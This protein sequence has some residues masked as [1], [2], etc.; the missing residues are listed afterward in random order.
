MCIM[1]WLLQIALVEGWTLVSH[2][3][4]KKPANLFYNMYI[5]SGLILCL[6]RHNEHELIHTTFLQLVQSNRFDLGYPP[7]H[8]LKKHMLS[9]S[10]SV[11][12]CAS[13]FQWSRLFV[14]NIQYLGV[15]IPYRIFSWRSMFMEAELL[16]VYHVQGPVVQKPVSL[17]LG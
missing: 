3:N 1:F 2:W 13:E 17:T 14:S 16:V 9:Y 5:P 7:I 4:H 6:L 10:L 12:W 11:N 15:I 8:H